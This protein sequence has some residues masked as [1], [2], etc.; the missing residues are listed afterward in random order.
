VYL[1]EKYYES[2]LLQFDKISVALN[3]KFSFR[4]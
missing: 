2:N 4:I 3:P 1:F